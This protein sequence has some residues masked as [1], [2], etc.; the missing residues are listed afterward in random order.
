MGYWVPHAKRPR[1]LNP[2]G[3]LPSRATSNKCLTKH[4]SGFYE[5]N[6]SEKRSGTLEGH[7]V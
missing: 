2:S 4:T 6:T 1:G 7:A 5:K 3:F